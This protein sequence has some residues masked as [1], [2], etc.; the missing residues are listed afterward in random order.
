[1][2][3]NEVIANDGII[4]ETANRGTLQINEFLPLLAH[5][6]LESLDLLIN[7][8]G[9]LTEHVCGMGTNKEKCK[10]YFDASPM[11]ITALLLFLHGKRPIC[12]SWREERQ[13]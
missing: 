13:P 12:P 7:I 3:M 10:E 6:L 2:N 11:I 4:T 1:M 5:A 9:L 8:N